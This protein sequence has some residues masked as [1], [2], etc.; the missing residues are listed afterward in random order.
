ME[1]KRTAG[2]Y[3]TGDPVVLDPAM[4]VHTAIGRLLEHNISG[5][6]VIDDLGNLVG[7]LTQRDC[8]AVALNAAYHQ[9]E[10]GKVVDYMSKEVETIDVTTGLVEVIER[11][12]RSRYRRFPVMSGTR[13]VGQISRRDV[14][15]ATQAYWR[16]ED[17]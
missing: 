9:S 4:D 10:G 14:L 13:L 11:F 15:R 2:E 5:A 7:I 1:P 8:M 3:M 16:G 12:N 6:P 17:L